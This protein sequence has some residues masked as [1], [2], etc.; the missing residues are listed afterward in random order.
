MPRPNFLK[1]KYLVNK[2]L[3]LKYAFWIGAALFVLMLLAQAHTYFTIESILP[4]LFSSALGRQ[5]RS[6]QTWL[7]LNSLI[8]LAVVVI[9]SVFL[10]HRIAGPV[11]H[12]EKEIREVLESNDPSRR[13]TLR[14]G[15]ELHSL[16]DQINKL[17]E[18][19]AQSQRR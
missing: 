14:K 13:I 18:R 17:L 15:D 2:P 5:A 11:Y 12:F 9:L 3:Q 6:L 8:Y 1:R 10:S 19:L 7:L 16:A 4:N